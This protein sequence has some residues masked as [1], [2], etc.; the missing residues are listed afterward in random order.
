MQSLKFQ[1][2]VRSSTVT[3]TTYRCFLMSMNPLFPSTNIFHNNHVHTTYHNQIIPSPHGMPAFESIPTISANI[4]ERDSFAKYDTSID[5]SGD[6]L[7]A[8][9]NL[10]M[11]SSSIQNLQRL[12]FFCNDGTFQFQPAVNLTA[13]N[14]LHVQRKLKNISYSAFNE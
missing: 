3:L 6:R 5:M 10:V 12:V 11:A 4:F 14:S 13:T 8:Y 7:E 9:A 2:F 1:R